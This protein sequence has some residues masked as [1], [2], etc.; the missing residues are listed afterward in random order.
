MLNSRGL[1]NEHLFTTGIGRDGMATETGDTTPETEEFDPYLRS[2]TVTTTATLMGIVAAVLSM[3]Y[4]TEGTSPDTFMGGL[5]LLGAI[6][7]QFPIYS[8]IGIDTAEFGTK[9]QLYIF[10]MT[11]ALW[12]V[13]WTLLLTT[14]ALQ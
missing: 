14:G 13:T 1:D 8:V 7:V 5:F 10:F 4:A 12:F 3:L 9:D 2:V 11:F 6:A